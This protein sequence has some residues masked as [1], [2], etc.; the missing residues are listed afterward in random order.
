MR[1]YCVPITTLR[2]SC[3]HIATGPRLKGY[4]A[5]IVVACRLSLIKVHPNLR[6][7]GRGVV[8]LASMCGAGCVMEDLILKIQTIRERLLAGTMIGG[9]ALA[10]AVALPVAAV[11]F[12]PTSASAQDF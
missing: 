11:V 10:A 6:A 9:V 8:Q 2:P 4:G 12:S 7:W 3:G 5:V 1:R